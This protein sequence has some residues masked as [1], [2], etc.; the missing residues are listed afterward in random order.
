MKHDDGARSGREPLDQLG[1]H[2]RRQIVARRRGEVA[3][4]RFVFGLVR[5]AP[6]AFEVFERFARRDPIDP[7]A[8]QLRLAQPADFAI[9]ENEDL[10][11]DVFG[12]RPRADEA[13]DVAIERLLQQPEEL[14]EGALLSLIALTFLLSP[15]KVKEL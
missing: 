8:K 9:Y 2:L 4:D 7:R 15:S 5:P 11:Q 12:R 6:F 3:Q 1:D 14:V 13:E 10:L